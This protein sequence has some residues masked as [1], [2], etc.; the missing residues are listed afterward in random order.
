MVTTD[1]GMLAIEI[2]KIANNQ[3][4]SNYRIS[5]D[6]IIHTTE[7]DYPVKIVESIEYHCDYNSS[8]SDYIILSCL[9]PAGDYVY[10][11]HKNRDLLE[12]SFIK[13]VNGGYYNSNVKQDNKLIK[14]YRLILLNNKN[15]LDGTRYSSSSKEELNALENIRLEGQC[16]NKTYEKIRLSRIDGVYRNTTID[17]L[18]RYSFSKELSKI[19]GD[20]KDKYRV[21]IDPIINDSVYDHIEVPTGTKLVDLPS[22]I[23]N[24]YYGAYNGDIGTYITEDMIIE[25]D[26]IKFINTAF[27][28]PLYDTKRFNRDDKKL[29]VYSTPDLKYSQVEHTYYV[30]GDLIKIIASHD[31][32]GFDTATD[33]LVNEASAI[34]YSK[35]DDLIMRNSVTTD[36]NTVV[37]ANIINSGE[38]NNELRDGTLNTVHLGAEANIYKYRSRLVRN[39]MMLYQIRWNYCDPDLLFPGM[40][41]MYIYEKEGKLIKLTGIVQ[42][43]YS[44]Y[45]AG[46]KSI[47]SILNIMI[48]KPLL[49]ES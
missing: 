36:K 35:P 31:A 22:Y 44:M 34:T 14:R 41:V 48:E 8:L 40:P 28:Y 38:L 42:S 7:I 32:V 9:I 20:D 10:D 26:N 15:S 43:F 12:V 2:N 21:T 5:Y 29:I 25:D 17:K 16:I 27:I 13:N 6:V 47:T 1:K 24:S 30:D 45:T 37:D 11:I 4:S 33:E 19:N 46:T 39:T 49:K 23:Q 18:I 3:N